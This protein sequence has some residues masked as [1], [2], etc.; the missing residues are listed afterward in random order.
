MDVDLHLHT[1]ASDGTL[2]PA[3]LVKA[4]AAA[5][6][7]VIAVADHDTLAGS[8]EANEAARGLPVHVV[9]AIEISASSPDLDLHMLGYFVDPSN[10][11]LQAYTREA[12]H[13]RERRLGEMIAR[14]AAQGVRVDF[15]A[16]VASTDG[17]GT[18]GRPHLARA[19]VSAG[20]ASSDQDAFERFIGNACPAYVPSSVV[21]PAQAIALISRSGGVSVWAHPPMHQIDAY[22]PILVG[23]GIK[24]IEV[25]RPGMLLSK[26]MKLEAAA[27]AA[28][29][30]LSG[31]SDW[32][33]PEAGPVGAFRI[34]AEQVAELLEVG[35]I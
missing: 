16:V 12:K 28:R 24:G 8:I 21:D 15:D 20:H 33:G 22:L 35:G 31:G 11:E 23:F 3:E 29:L 26:L 10:A 4:C 13:W 7:D 34:R 18:L 2:R 6:L 32:H 5:S 14:L 30:L 27:H 9:P 1:T 17:N 19:L 25:Y